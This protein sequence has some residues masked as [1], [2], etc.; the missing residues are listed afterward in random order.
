VRRRA[1]SPLPVTRSAPSFALESFHARATAGSPSTRFPLLMSAP[2]AKGHLRPPSLL[3]AKSVGGLDGWSGF[4]AQI[5]YILGALPRWLGDASTRGFQPERGEDVDVFLDEGGKQVVDHHQVKTG[6]QTVSAIKVYVKEFRDRYRDALV[7]G[8][9][10][11][12][13]IATPSPNQDVRSLFIA[14]RRFRETRFLGSHDPQR[15]ETLADL[16]MRFARAGIEDEDFEFVLERLELTHDW[17]GLE[18]EHEPWGRI[19]G[20]LGR[21]EDFSG[22]T[23]TELVV[24]AKELALAIDQRKR[25]FWDRAEIVAFVTDSVERWRSGPPTTSGDVVLLCHQSRSP[26]PTHPDATVLPDRLRGRRI[27]RHTVAHP[28][29]YD[30]K[31]WS[32]LAEALASMFISDGPFQQALTKART[33]PVVYYGFPHIPLAALAGYLFGEQCTIHFVEHDRDLGLFAW[34]ESTTEAPTLEPR[35]T[36]EGA[37]G[38]VVLRISISAPVVPELC[39]ICVDDQCGVEVTCAVPTPQRGIVRSEAQARAYAKVI[40]QTLDP[41]IA[42]N[43]AVTSL[44]VFAA[45][46]VSIAFLVGQIASSTGFPPT[47]VYNFRNSDLPPYH[48]ALCLEK[49]RRGDGL[50]L[51][52]ARDD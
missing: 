41:L 6:S 11:R 44:H 26:V 19:A 34:P 18:A 52:V 48:W 45:V 13:I 2:P 23:V 47:Y 7:A 8:T 38:P 35:T 46:P 22:L 9:V 43:P 31:D 28:E 37:S 17:G 32:A 4:S 14:L 36:N 29:L 24:A 1:T 12:F 20:E 39:R 33:S 21:V 49:V 27:L 10:G 42:G 51:P 30:P 16:R 15:T 25:Y 40:R 50:V 5:R 3:D